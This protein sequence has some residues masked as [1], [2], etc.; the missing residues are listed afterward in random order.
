MILC[1][2][3]EVRICNKEQFIHYFNKG[4]DPK[5]KNTLLVKIEDLNKFSNVKIKVRCDNEYCDVEKILRYSKY[6]KNTK[7]LTED[8]CCSNKCALDKIEKT[9]IKKY[10]VKYPAQIK[11]I[12]EKTKKTKFERYGDEH[13]VNIEKRNI[14]NLEKYGESP[15]K[16]ESVKEKMRNSFIK[17]Y[18][19]DSPFKDAGI[20]NK[21]KSIYLE[22]YGVDHPMQ[23]VEI[24]KKQQTTSFKVSRYNETDLTYQGSYEKYFLDKMYSIGKI[25]EVS[26]GKSYVYIIDGKNHTYHSDYLFNNKTIEIKSNW[27]YDRNGLDKKLGLKNEIKFKTVRNLGDDIIVLKSIEEIDKFID[28]LN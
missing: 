16:N 11:E 13:F 14:S 5:W 19:V 15:N 8:Y 12:Y 6:I 1:E 26:N 24:F 23:N 7:N 27:T 21:I 2:E 18:G 22:K 20:Q 3:V 9:N 28:K 4:Y 25:D 17:K 10:G